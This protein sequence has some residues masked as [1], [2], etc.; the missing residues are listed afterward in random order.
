MEELNNRGLR[1]N[2]SKPKWSLV[3]QTALI[4]MVR[5]LEFGATKY[6]SYN[7]FSI[8]A[9]GKII[10]N[11]LW[12]KLQNVQDVKM[13]KI[14]LQE[15]YADSVIQKS[16]EEK[17]IVQNVE[18]LEKLLLKQDYVNPVMK[19]TDFQKEQK[20]LIENIFT[21]KNI[22]QDLKTK[23]EK[24][25]EIQKEE[26]TQNFKRNKEEI[27]SLEILQNMVLKKM[28]TEILYQED[29]QS[30]EV[31]KD[32]IL[33]MTIQLGNLET[34]FVVSATKLLDCYKI[35]LKL[36]EIF[37]NISLN[38]S[39]ISKKIPGNHNWMKGLS[40]TEI[41][42]SLKRHLD[43]F[44]E[45]ENTDKESLLSHIG[46]IQCN[47]LFLSWMMENR[48]DLDDR[49]NIEDFKQKEKEE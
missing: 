47:A 43:A 28:S 30:V 7:L 13:I 23:K 25:L 2:D 15:G 3:P 19:N 31:K 42:E 26:Q 10:N 16:Q 32:H 1:F 8:F 22:I 5:V 40:V 11:K 29:V 49:T 17:L 33:T 41:C 39:D 9:I 44:M 18:T 20:N 14:L 37:F 45:G 48:P 46:H 6:S 27:L 4:P 38:I 12:E 35:I 36:L 21:N 34:Y 24:E